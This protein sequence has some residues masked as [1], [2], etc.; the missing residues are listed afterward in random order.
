MIKETKE[1]SDLCFSIETRFHLKSKI[2][3]HCTIENRDVS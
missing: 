2:N 3:C 1:I